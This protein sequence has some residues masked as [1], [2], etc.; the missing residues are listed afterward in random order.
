M[1]TLTASSAPAASDRGWTYLIDKLEADGISRTRTRKVFYD[2]RVR[3]HSHLDYGLYPKESARLY[4]GFRSRSSIAAARRCRAKYAR[5]FDRAQKRF[6]V[7][8]SIVASVFHVE[9]RCGENKGKDVALYRLARLAMANEPRN[10]VRNIKRH[11]KGAPRAKLAQIEE[12][13]RY[14]G[15]YLEDIFYPEVVAAFQIGT[16]LRID[17]LDIIG[18]KA[19]AFG[20]PQFLPSSYMRFAVD[21][22]GDGKVS[23]HEP[24]DAAYS[25]ANFLSGNGWRPGITGA[26]KREVIWAYNRSDA[27]ID[28]ILFLSDQIER[29][30]N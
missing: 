11:Q 14:R 10:V 9:T 21:G 8:A 2:S 6:G 24:A 15:K 18:S 26:K 7:P 1:S 5:E 28:T 25:A 22:N 12:R 23:L 30:R 17:P 16:K 4:R 3:P 20:I 29:T 13:T 19:G 27:Y